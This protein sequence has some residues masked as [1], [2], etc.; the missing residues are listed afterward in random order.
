MSKYRKIFGFFGLTLLVVGSF[1]P[2]LVPS[3]NLLLLSVP[4][5]AGFCSLIVHTILCLKN[6]TGVRKWI[7]IVGLLSIGLALIIIF[8]VILLNR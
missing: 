5:V 8:F 3:G 4:S 6:M 7:N 1:L 2:H